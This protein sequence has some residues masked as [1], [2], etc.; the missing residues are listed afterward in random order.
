MRN[1]LPVHIALPGKH[2]IAQFMHF[3]RQFLTA[4]DFECNIL[5][6]NSLCIVNLAFSKGF[7]E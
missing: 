3:P 4:V 2:L 1:N 7:S 5:N 6:Y